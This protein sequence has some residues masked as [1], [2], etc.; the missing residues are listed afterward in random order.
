MKDHLA[1][2]T[3]EAVLLSLKEQNYEPEQLIFSD[4]KYGSVTMK[5]TNLLRSPRVEF[6][7]KRTRDN[8]TKSYLTFSMALS[9]MLREE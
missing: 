4:I 1:N 5:V 2:V 9:Y 7:A 3:F 8:T 6:V